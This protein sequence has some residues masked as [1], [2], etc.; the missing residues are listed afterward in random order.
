MTIQSMI[1][2]SRKLLIATKAM[3]E[4]ESR[5]KYNGKDIKEYKYDPEGYAKYV[6]KQTLTPDQLD[7]AKKI[8]TP[9]YRVL[10]R[11]GH[12]VGKSFCAAFIVSW[13]FDTRDDCMIITTAPT[14]ASVRDIL[15]RELRKLRNPI[16]ILAKA[17]TGPRSLRMETSPTHIAVGITAA[18]STGFQGKHEHAVFC[19]IDE[20]VGVEKEFW[21]AIET[22]LT[23]EEFGLLSICNPTTTACQAYLEEK[24]QGNHIHV[25][26]ALNHPNIQAEL[27]GLPAP[28]PAAIRLVSIMKW[29][30]KWCDKLGFAEDP[31][32]TDFEF[33][34]GTGIYY[35]PGPIA[36]SRIL[37]R[38]PTSGIDTVWNEVLVDYCMDTP[39]KLDDNWPVT[40]G[41]DI[42]RF[43][44][45]MTEIVVRKGLCIMEHES[46][47][48]WRSGQVAGRLKQLAT[49]YAF[50]NQSRFSIPIYIDDTG[51][52]GH[53]A[54]DQAGE[55]NFVG[56][57][58]A[59]EA[60]D[61]ILYHRTRTELWFAAVE[62]ARMKM[63]DMTR[64]TSDSK[65][66]LRRQLLGQ[67]YKILP[68][69]QMYCLEK[70][71]IKEIL[72]RSPDT[73]DAFNLALLPPGYANRLETV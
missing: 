48:G 40:I 31:K 5:I 55:Y 57:N 61:K 18:K 15:W 6:V 1:M 73:A 10:C 43:G 8:I 32:E 24:E 30:D 62:C 27:Q 52:W 53:G 14:L 38:W 3:I 7:L 9:P 11:A 59:T 64:L 44:D 45:D 46:H 36:E 39:I 19:I 12:V 23:G 68:S 35:R 42:A 60:T 69:G 20:S 33:P 66:E 65:K 51:G 63:V 13:L 72:G 54:I 21:E 71:D 37:G 4:D 58:V 47:S 29:L 25:I 70:D 34:V 67:K 56:I 22:M 2:K 17:F 49:Q 28:Y 26:S 16:P 50:P 41:C